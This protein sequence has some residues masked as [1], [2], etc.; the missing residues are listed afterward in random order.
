MSRAK[1]LLWVA[2]CLVSC[3]TAAVTPEPGVYAGSLALQAI[4]SG[5]SCTDA[6][7]AAG[8]PCCEE[9][10]PAQLHIMEEGAFPRANH[11][12]AIKRDEA[13]I[14]TQTERGTYFGCHTERWD[15]WSMLADGTTHVERLVNLKCSKPQSTLVCRYTGLVTAE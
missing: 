1:F 13:L 12:H 15:R 9:R 5:T 6:T 4:A 7:R 14:W 10:I 2:I 3:G 11:E 8:A